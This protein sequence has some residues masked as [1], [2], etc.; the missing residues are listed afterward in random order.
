MKILTKIR[1]II[2]LSLFFIIPCCLQEPEYPV[3][4]YIEYEDFIKTPDI[5]GGIDD[6]G[7]LKISFTDGDGD[8]GLA[9]GDTTAPFEGEYYYNFFIKYF[10]RQNGVFKEIV[11]SF[12]HNARIPVI[13]PKGEDKAIKGE[14][15]IENVFIKNSSSNYDT[16]R[17]QAYIVDRALHHSNTITTPDIIVK[18]H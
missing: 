17:F 5:Q 15:I 7:I 13:S 2:I 4:P 6:T 14:I 8:I 10:E 12:P 9:Q 16:I 3:I 11:L 1:F 18:K